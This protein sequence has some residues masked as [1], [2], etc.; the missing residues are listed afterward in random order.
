MHP[1]EERVKMEFLIPLKRN[2]DR[3]LHDAALWRLLRLALYAVAGG[4]SSI[5][6]IKSKETYTGSWRNP[7]SMEPV[8]DESREYSV[9][10]ERS[11]ESLL[12]EV[13]ERSCNSLDQEE[14]L[15][16]VQG[17][18]RSVRRDPGKGFLEGDP[19]EG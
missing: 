13:L 17:V 2:S 14:I 8:E 1:T 5:I 19:S 18:D 4:E 3:R 9:V 16:L 15:F 11:K 10:I 12:R 6:V 7:Q